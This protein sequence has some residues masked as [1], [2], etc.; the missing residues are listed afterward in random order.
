[1][2]ADYADYKAEVSHSD[3]VSLAAELVLIMRYAASL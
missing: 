3:M 1:M 2:Y